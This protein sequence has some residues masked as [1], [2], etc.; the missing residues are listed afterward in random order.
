MRNSDSTRRR[1]LRVAA[2]AGALGVAG[3]IG[4]DVDPDEDDP[5]DDE[6]DEVAPDD[7]EDDE[8]EP[9]DDDDEPEDV[10]H[11]IRWG[12]STGGTM[13]VGLAFE[14]AVGEHSDTVSYSTIES[15]GY[16]GTTYRLN[17]DEFDGG[18]IDTNTMFNAQ[19]GM[20]DF[21]DEPVEK[22]PWQGFL[23]FPY[24][25][26]VMALED[27]GIETFDDLAGATVYPAEPGFST[28]ATTLDLWA[29]EPTA[30]VY[31]E[32][33]IVDMDVDDAPGA[34]EEG[35]I[36]AAIAY[37]TPGVGNTGWV[38]EYDARVDVNYVEH[39]DA[40]IESIEQ[41]DGATL[42][43][44]DNAQEEFG[45]DQDIGTDE[46]V[47]WDLIITFAFHPETD[48][49]AAYE[50]TRIAGEHYDTVSDA[51]ARFTAEGPEDL[52]LGALDDY[53]FHPGAAEYY[54][55]E[56]V[57]DDD[58]VVGDQDDIGGYFAD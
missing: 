29:M 27:T 54:E 26:Y 33:E 10:E 23:A 50:L 57:W 28:R 55:E 31:E 21:E 19:Q 16:I 41:F 13:D 45:W 58:W 38:V 47:S 25:I 42:G 36:D 2:G 22:L 7:D 12:T 39:T 17:E 5:L 9:D 35:A 53:P 4:E 56:G 3:C 30:D 48:H 11:E 14:A 24:A 32:M 46:I 18:I 51:E 43:E 20:G 6:D 15:P 49:E 37:G 44:Y 52:L 1:F 34:M 40:L 8:A